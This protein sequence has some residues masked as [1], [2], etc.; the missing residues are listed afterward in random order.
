MHVLDLDLQRSTALYQMNAPFIKPIVRLIV[1]AKAQ[2]GTDAGGFPIYDTAF[3]TYDFDI[4]DRLLGR[5]TYSMQK[6]RFAGDEL[7][8]GLPID[9]SLELLNSDGY[10]ATFQN[11]YGLRA[12]DIEQGQVRIY[13]NVTVGNP[14][15]MFQG[16][17][18]GRP[19]ETKGRTVIKARGS[20]WD[21]IRKPVTYEH[22]SGM[23][24]SS[25]GSTFTT[26]AAHLTAVGGDFCVFHGLVKWDS[27]GRPQPAFKQEAGTV[28]LTSINILTG[29]KLGV[30]RI[31][32]RDATNYTITYPDNQAYTG[33][34]LL[35]L[36]SPTITIDKTAWT[37]DDGTDTV[38]EFEVGVAYKG[39]PVA[40]AY[41]LLEKGLLSNW[42][43]LPQLQPA[44]RILW[45]KFEE[46]AQRF[47]TFIVYVDAS[48]PDNKV[49]DKRGSELPLDTAALA[50]WVLKHVSCT[51][52]I[53]PDGLIT[54]VSPYI[55]DNNV[56]PIQT[57]SDI[58]ADG[59][60]IEGTSEAINYLTLQYGH[61]SRSNTFGGSWTE[62]FRLNATSE[63]VEVVANA[64]FYKFPISLQEARWLAETYKRRHFYG[65]QAQTVISFNVTPQ[66]GLTL[67]P[68]DV[69]R[70]VSLSP[71]YVSVIC[72]II[73]VDMEIGGAVG[74]KA[75]T[76][77][78]LAEGEPAEVCTA[79]YGSVTL[80]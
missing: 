40:I 30:Y 68:G 5:V 50:Q 53:T 17:I 13:A 15:E 74:I 11:G 10:L 32:F 37:G 34:K 59:I 21:A 67:M 73:S 56:W 38:I 47:K 60:T 45:S 22:F 8:D 26:Q 36:T 3:A 31:E 33:S 9:L 69:V 62:D 61:D 28:S 16:R 24:A 79:Q 75:A 78:Q 43:D 58:L 44:V 63:L 46:L 49:W 57:T 18:V 65:R 48:N 77:Q 55:D 25:D 64:H 35:D 51:L 39:N 66:M 54:L 20:L 70:V 71:P 7:F 41:N 14:I 29:A 4:T 1:S 72:E 19:T 2:T 6:P 27:N 80:W 52:A 76:I 12:E 42:G 23:N